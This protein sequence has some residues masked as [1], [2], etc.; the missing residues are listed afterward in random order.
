ML[1]EAR[2]RFSHD[3]V[4]LGRVD[5]PE[6]ARASLAVQVGVEWANGPKAGQDLG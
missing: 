2:A 6:S 3:T 1:T 5:S 4:L